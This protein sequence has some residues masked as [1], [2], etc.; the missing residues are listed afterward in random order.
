MALHVMNMRKVRLRNYQQRSG[1]ICYRGVTESGDHGWSVAEVILCGAEV[2]GRGRA[3]GW[4]RASE[5]PRWK[6]PR[7][8]EQ[9]LEWLQSDEGFY[10][11]GHVASSCEGQILTATTIMYSCVQTPLVHVWDKYLRTSYFYF[12]LKKPSRKIWVMY[13][14]PTTSTLTR[15]SVEDVYT[16]RIRK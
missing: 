7:G 1:M 5:L 4:L 6:C 16:K 8:K 10:L 13:M 11:L 14:S 15:A 3:P 2:S 12:L 9:L